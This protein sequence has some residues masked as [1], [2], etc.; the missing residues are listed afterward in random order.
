MGY[1]R[2]TPTVTVPDLQAVTDQ[3][4]V[5]TLRI[6]AESFLGDGSPLANV[7]KNG[8]DTFTSAPTVDNL[9]SLTQSEYDALLL[10][11]NDDANT[12][13]IYETV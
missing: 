3:G 6:Q 2:P 7:V 10:A 1:T 4:N 12:L 5:T 13:Y 11:G 9:V 8:T